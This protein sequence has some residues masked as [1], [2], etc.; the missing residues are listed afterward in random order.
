[1]ADEDAK[2]AVTSV[3]S[4]QRAASL[5]RLGELRPIFLALHIGGGLVGLP[6]LIITFLATSKIP[7]QPALINFCVAWVINSISYTLVSLGGT[8]HTASTPLC[9][10]QA[11]MLNGAPPMAGVG[12]FLVVF[13]I[14]RTFRD[15]ISLRVYGGRQCSEKAAL[16]V[17]LS[18][19]Y[20]V[21]ILFTITSL[22]LQI[23]SPHT[24]DRS[25]GLYCT[26]T[27]L[28]FRRW[29]V[30]L[31]TVT[32]LILMLGF[33]IAIAIRYYLARQR[34][35]NSFPLANRST[36]RGLV[37]RISLFNIYLLITFGASVVFLSGAIQPWA[38]MVQAALS[39]VAF[40]LFATQKNV[41]DAW[42][43]WKKSNNET[44]SDES[45]PAL[46][47]HGPNVDAGINL[48]PPS[49]D[50]IAADRV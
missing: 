24:L 37:I 46:R 9:F 43:F 39:M 22:V 47:K 7:R 34:I 35:L 40:V 14:W 33:E 12:T 28:A 31:S 45:V 41:F 21:F 15:P 30:P 6:L 19:P 27:G 29:S 4:T 20:I 18:L 50:I 44:H 26:V 11:A 32:I 8:S 42:C 38:Y 13:Q 1:M 36:S 49:P 48:D 10:S 2:F 3:A 23:K 5:A 16:F 25:N 17:T